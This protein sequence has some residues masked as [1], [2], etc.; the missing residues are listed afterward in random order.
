MPFTS[1]LLQMRDQEVKP[2]ARPKL[3]KTL[4]SLIV[5]TQNLLGDKLSMQYLVSAVGVQQNSTT[6]SCD[7]SAA[8]LEEGFSFSAQ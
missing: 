1:K 2:T 3:E 6:S 7:D 4:M 5:C 8:D